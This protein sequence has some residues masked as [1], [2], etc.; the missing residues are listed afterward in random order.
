MDYEA[1]LDLPTSV[2]NRLIER[3]KARIEREVDLEV[4]KLKAVR[5]FLTGK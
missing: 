5:K 1:V 2:R 3:T 4:Q